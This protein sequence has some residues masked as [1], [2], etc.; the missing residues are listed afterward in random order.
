M[1]KK[2]TTKA[3]QEKKAANKAAAKRLK[4]RPKT[5][6][7]AMHC[8]IP[9]EL[10]R[11]QTI[12]LTRLQ[13]DEDY[14]RLINNRRV[15]HIAENFCYMKAGTLSVSQ[16]PDGSLWV[17]D[18]QHRLV[19]MIRRGDIVSISCLVYDLADKYE[20]AE[21]FVICNDGIRKLSAVEKHHAS[22]F[23]KDPVAVSV[24]RVLE[25]HDLQPTDRRVSDG[26]RSIG[27]L[28]KAMTNDAAL[29]TRT[30]DLLVA[31]RGDE[32]VIPSHAFSIVHSL[33]RRFREEEDILKKGS[34]Y[35]NRITS[36]GVVGLDAVYQEVKRT[37]KSG[38][39]P[40]VSRVVWAT[41]SK[42]LRNRPQFDN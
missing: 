2:S 21:A 26:F 28:T 14:Q 38:N 34:R 25:R 16:R 18:G 3:A 20:E 5:N 17:F 6:T 29:A 31:A 10:G 22:Y 11:V 4:N 9:D 13:I 36:M 30:F 33:A 37:T 8:K 23:A 19:A 12:A 32:K 24:Q 40:A 1:S 39:T 42:G 15:L 41:L 27:L 35:Y 7:S